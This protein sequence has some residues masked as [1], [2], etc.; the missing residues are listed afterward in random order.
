MQ[1]QKGKLASKGKRFAVAIIDFIFVPI[2]FGLAM[3]LIFFA[4]KPEPRIQTVFMTVIIIA[5]TI[6]R[7][8]YFSLGRAMVGI[9]LQKKDGGSVGFGTAIVRNIH[10]MIPF[11]SILGL[12]VEFIALLSSGH[13]L[14]DQWA[15]TVVVDK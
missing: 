8:V 10:L 14:S 9:K 3:G 4:T 5:W 7:D 13:R 15:H 11:I 12:L 1:Q 6:F 2:V